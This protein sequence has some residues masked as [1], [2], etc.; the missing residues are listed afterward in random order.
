MKDI[1]VG[2]KNSYLVSYQLLT[3][4]IEEESNIS[5]MLPDLI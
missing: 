4:K 3:S 1:T 2:G 5:R